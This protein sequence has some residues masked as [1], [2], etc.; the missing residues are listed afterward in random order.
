MGDPRLLI[1]RLKRDLSRNHCDAL[2]LGG[3]LI[4]GGGEV[5][6]AAAVT[7]FSDITIPTIVVPGNHD[8]SQKANF[9]LW[10]QKF[11]ASPQASF[12]DSLISNSECDILALS[13][14]WLSGDGPGYWFHRLEY[15]GPWF[16]DRQLEWLDRELEISKT[17]PAIVLM[18]SPIFRAG[19]VRA[20]FQAHR[21]RVL[22][23]IERHPRVRLLLSGHTHETTYMRDPMTGRYDVTL[24]A[25][26][27]P[28][29]PWLL[30]EIE[31]GRFRVTLRTLA[32]SEDRFS[33]P[34]ITS[35]AGSL[36]PLEFE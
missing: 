25:L 27:E 23:I 33:S 21:R 9:E 1:G 12:G 13:N 32:T 19:R 35:T 18:H 24:G 28:P 20:Y 34:K 4:E 22:N 5:E 15:F 11:A 16:F 3:D 29:C 14:C 36:S 30:I 26:L 10:R 8:L 31:T 7:L 17:R 6:I 2:L